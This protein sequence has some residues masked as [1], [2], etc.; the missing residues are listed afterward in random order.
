VREIFLKAVDQMVARKPE[1]FETIG[2]IG[3]PDPINDQWD[4]QATENAK[5]TLSRESR[6]VAWEGNYFTAPYGD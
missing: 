6:L 5:S 3:K 1:N 2:A 4:K